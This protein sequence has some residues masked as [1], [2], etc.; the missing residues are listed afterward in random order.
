[1]GNSTDYSAIKTKTI[2]RR[3]DKIK[4][5]LPIFRQ[6]ISNSG[7]SPEKM[8]QITRKDVPAL[9]QELNARN[10]SSELLLAI[11]AERAC[12]IGVNNCIITEEYF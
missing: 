2:D 10:I 6:I 3:S 5:Y 1:M 9:V 4:H 8:D 11:Y 7:L 12:T